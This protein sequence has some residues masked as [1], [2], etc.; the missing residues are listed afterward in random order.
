MKKITFALCVLYF[1]AFTSTLY[2]QNTEVLYLSGKDKDHTVLWN[3]KIS[4]G[5]NCCRWTQIPVPS[6]WELQ[7]FG[8]YNYGRDPRPDEKPA[9]ETG[10]YRYD[11]RVPKTWK[12]RVISIVFEGVM[13]DTRVLVNGKTAGPV[14]QGGFYRFSYDISRLISY[15]KTNRLEVT[16]RAAHPRARLGL[17]LLG[18]GH[19]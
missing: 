5:S 18:Y 10:I 9:D 1:S 4:G 8:R 15:D 17:S 19:E 2:A 14:H 13:T 3:F 12:G 11:F 16:V 6:N 7:G